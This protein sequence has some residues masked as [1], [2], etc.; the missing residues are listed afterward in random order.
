MKSFSSRKS[1]RQSI[2]D[3]DVVPIGARANFGQQEMLVPQCSSK[4]DETP[5]SCFEFC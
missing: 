3:F 2:L 5:A 1:V 4:C